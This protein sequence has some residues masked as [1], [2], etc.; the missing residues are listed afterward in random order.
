M[1]KTTK[2]NEEQTLVDRQPA[3]TARALSQSVSRVVSESQQS[4]ASGN[5]DWYESSIIDI[6]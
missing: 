3:A 4:R 5:P 1:E 2:I 6:P